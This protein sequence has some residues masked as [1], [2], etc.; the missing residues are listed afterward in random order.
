MKTHFQMG[1]I[2]ILLAG[3]AQAGDAEFALCEGDV[4]NSVIRVANCDLAIRLGDLSAEQLRI[5][6]YNRGQAYLTL[7]N[8]EK[9]ME[10][11][12]ALLDADP[13]DG[14]ALLLRG[15]ALRQLKQL[16]AAIADFDQLLQLPYEPKAQVYL[17]RSMAYHLKGDKD[18][19]LAD[20]QEAQALAPEDRAISERLWKTR[21]LY[22]NE[23]RGL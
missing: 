3:A 22:E 15:I 16:D 4:E 9:A 10:D 17:H 20:L 19:T 1:L 11:F 5:A 14:G 18:K 8:P 21:R 13:Q 6:Q 7:Q 12:E 23:A 2:A